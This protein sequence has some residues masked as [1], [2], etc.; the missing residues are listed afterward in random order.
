MEPLARATLPGVTLHP[1]AA[2]FASVADVY[3]RGRPD[4]A[5]A[6]VGALAAELHIAPGAPGLGLAAGTRKLTR[7]VLAEGLDV[8]GLEPQGQLRGTLATI[9][10][11][12]AG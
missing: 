2:Q 11:R 1:L 3:E 6:V 4:Y 7:A 10:G 5:P 12:Q 8:V 9:I